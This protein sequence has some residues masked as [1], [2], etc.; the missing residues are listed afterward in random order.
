MLGILN[1][2]LAQFFFKQTCAALEGP[3]ESYL[4]FFG[5]YL[6]GF[7]VRTVPAKDGEKIIDRVAHRTSLT[8]QLESAK[9]PESK[10]RL[11]REIDAT[12]CRIDQL[13]Y[14]LYGLTDKEIALVE[15]REG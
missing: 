6:E 9:N 8:A 1:S 4:R 12:D 11:H 5:Q 14:E 10:T 3:G 15:G 2:R 7:P 13:V